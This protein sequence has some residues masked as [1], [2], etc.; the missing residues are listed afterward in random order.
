M[1]SGATEG[2]MKLDTNVFH[3]VLVSFKA[4]VHIRVFEI[5]CIIY[6]GYV[7]R[8]F[9]TFPS[10]VL[11]I[12]GI[13]NSYTLSYRHFIY[14]LIFFHKN[15]RK[16]ISLLYDQHE[17]ALTQ[18]S[19]YKCQEVISSGVKLICKK[20]HIFNILPICQHS[21]TKTFISWK[22]ISFLIVLINLIGSPYAKE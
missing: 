2:E 16:N 22:W 1:C 14:R 13:K 9:K 20:W 21:S 15:S 10:R 11:N 3:I 19:L 6:Q 17:R 12:S 7:S 5:N 18:M 4:I 8:S